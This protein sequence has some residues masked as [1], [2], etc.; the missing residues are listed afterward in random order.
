[1]KPFDVKRVLETI[2][3]QLKKQEEERNYSQDK[4][5]AFI[6]TRVKELTVNEGKNKK[7]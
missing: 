5:A 6:E 7:P 1:M 3:D 2:E 4:V